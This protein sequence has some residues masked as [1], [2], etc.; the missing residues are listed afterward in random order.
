MCASPCPPLRQ[1]LVSRVPLLC[2]LDSGLTG[3]VL[4]SSLVEALQLQHLVSAAPP[5]SLQDAAASSRVASLSLSLRTELGG[6]VRLGASRDS[7]PLFY[8]QAVSLN[9]FRPELG[10]PHVVALGQCVLGSGVLTVDGPQRRATWTQG[11]A[12]ERETT[13]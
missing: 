10:E 1:V 12:A 2:V 8:T 5:Y 3:V 13:A 6:T 7:S 4:S 9:W 11:A